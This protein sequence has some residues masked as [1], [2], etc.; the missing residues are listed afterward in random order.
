MLDGG[1]GSEPFFLKGGWISN[2]E[3]VFQKYDNKL[4][5]EMVEYATNLNSKVG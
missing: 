2:E 4:E 3:E 5:K 1:N